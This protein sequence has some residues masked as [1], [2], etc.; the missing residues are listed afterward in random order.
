M[1]VS[2][3]MLLAAGLLSFAV[4]VFQVVILFSPAWCLYFGAP[5]SVTR[6]L[7]RLYFT[8]GVAAVCFALFGMYA[9]SGVRVVRRLPLLRSGLVLISAIYTVRGLL[10]IPV[11]LIT[12]GIISIPDPLPPTALAGSLVSLGI[13]LVF[14]L[15]TAGCWRDLKP[16]R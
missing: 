6:D 15:G 11:I 5:E 12:R 4:A 16:L 1:T 2:R 10:F 3:R 8:G 7:P 9:L 13:G 14:L